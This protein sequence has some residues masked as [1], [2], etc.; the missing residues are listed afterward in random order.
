MVTE[1]VE[2]LEPIGRNWHVRLSF[3]KENVI[4]W[5][6]DIVSPLYDCNI[7]HD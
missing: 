6:I 2:I 1:M 3:S 4:H 7:P 5:S